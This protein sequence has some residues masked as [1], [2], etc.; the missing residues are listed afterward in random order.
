MLR[1]LYYAGNLFLTQETL[2][3][4]GITISSRHPQQSNPLHLRQHQLSEQP[5]FKV[6]DAQKI[7]L[8]TDEP[9]AELVFAFRAAA[10]TGFVTSVSKITMHQQG[11]STRAFLSYA[12]L[13]F[14]VQSISFSFSSFLEDQ[15]KRQGVRK[16]GPGTVALLVHGYFAHTRHEPCCC[17]C[18]KCKH[19]LRQGLI[20]I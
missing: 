5:D 2:R 20:C 15:H 16:E 12:F 11:Y 3:N 9:L 8:Y 10:A 19:Q 6:S 7:E 4:T 18:S 14:E 17:C 1:T 13:S